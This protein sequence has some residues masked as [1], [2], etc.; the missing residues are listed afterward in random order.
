MKSFSILSLITVFLSLAVFANEADEQRPATDTNIFGHVVDAETGQHLP[1]ITLMVKGTRIGTMTD[2]TGHFMLTNLPFGEQVIVVQGVGYE[3][4]TH[5]VFLEANKSIEVDFEL[6]PVAISLQEFVITSSPTASGFRYQPDRV[7]LGEEL[8]RKNEASFGEMLRKESGLNMRSLGSAPS[9]PVIRGLDGARI[10]VLQNGERMGD[11]SETSAD[12]SISLDPLA[13]SRVDVVRGPASLLYGPSALGG[14]VNIFTT[15][16][17]DDVGNETSGVLSLQGANANSMMAGFGRVTVGTGNWAGTARLSLRNAE[18]TN[19]PTG[20]IPGTELRNFDGA[21]GAA[22]IGNNS[23][24]G[25]SLSLNNQAFGLPV[26]SLLDDE[27]VE[28]RM[29][30]LSAQGRYNFRRTG[31]FDKG[32]LR[33]N[34]ATMH[35][36]EVEMENGEEETGLSFL[37]NSMSSSLTIQHRP[38]SFFDRGAIGLNLFAHNMEVKGGEAFSPGERKISAGVFTFQE[39]PLSNTFRLQYGLRLDAQ[40]TA[41]LSNQVFPNSNQSRTTLNYSGSLGVNHRPLPGWEIGAQLAR[42]HRNPKVQELFSDGV[43]IGAG[44]YEVGNPRLKDEVGN[45]GDLFVKYSNKRFDAE[46]AIFH[47]RFLNYIIFAPTG[48]IDEPSGFPVFRYERDLASLWGGE[49]SAAWRPANFFQVDFG[50]DYV[51]GQRI[52]DE[53]EPLPFIPPLRVK[54]SFE[55]DL[56]NFWFGA[57]AMAVSAQNRVA[58]DELPTDG[59]LLLGA[60]AGIRLNK[61]GRHVLMIRADNLLDIAY[62]DHLSRMENRNFLMPG[63]NLNLAYRWFF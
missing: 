56:D 30:R 49:F 48:I 51:Q 62:R 44:V 33:I 23:S 50:V 57:N 58:P 15:D 40:H 60:T 42:S 47:N 1:F 31:F 26:F 41:A 10:L 2:A 12:H 5:K 37:K 53:I 24:G 17:P 63:R 9:R 55:F 34:L 59:Y 4:L 32:Q 46:L 29:Q 43:H 20:P 38:F 11:I 28:I 52:S 19:T 8:Q 7:I 36:D 54:T 21:L 6:R 45:G 16:I 27:R 35:Q 61:G 13:A 14:V 39:I 3:R 22:F 25:V 18:E